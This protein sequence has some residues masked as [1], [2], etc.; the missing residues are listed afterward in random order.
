MPRKKVILPR[1]FPCSLLLASLLL[2]L[3]SCH[4]IQ[5]GEVTTDPATTEDSSEEETPTAENLSYYTNPILDDKG[6]PFV[7]RWN[8]KYYLYPSSGSSRIECW[9]SDNLVDW[10]YA[11]V[12]A[13]GSTIWGAYAPEVVY[14]N[15]YFYLYTSPAGNGH[16]V[17][18]SDSPTGPF[19]LISGNVGRGI[20]GDVFIDDDGQWY[21]FTSGGS[22]ITKYKMSS[23]T[24][25]DGGTALTEASMNGGWTEG[26]NVVKHDGLYYLT[27]TGNHVLHKGYRIGYAV[28]DS[29]ESLVKGS[30]TLLVSTTDEVF[31]TGHSST[32]KGPDLDSYWI[33]Y[34]TLIDV[35]NESPSRSMNIDR[36]IFNGS[37]LEVLG[38]TTTEQVAPSL[39]DF[40]SWFTEEDASAD[41]EGGLVKDGKL[42]L[43][44]GEIV[45]STSSYTGDF[46]AEF[47]FSDISDSGSGSLLFQ[48]SDSQN[49]LLATLDAPT[50][51]LTIQA[52]ESGV[53]RQLAA[54]SLPTSFGERVRLDC[55]QS[56]QI[57]RSDSEYTFFFNDHELGSLTLSADS[58]ASYRFGFTANQTQLSIS[59]VG[60]TGEVH[61]SSASSQYK[62]LP[63]T[64]Q[65][66]DCLNPQENSLSAQITDK[67]YAD[68]SALEVKA[69]QTYSYRV[70]I[71]QAQ[72][73]DLGLYYRSDQE[74]EVTI[75]V[76]G[77]AIY[78]G[79]FPASSEYATQ[80]LRNIPLPEGNHLLSFTYSTD[81]QAAELELIA[82]EEVEALTVTFDKEEDDP[83]SYTDGPWTI[84]DGKLVMPDGI[85][86]VGKRL[87]GSDG[88]GD[89]AVEID[90][91][92][93]G[94]MN[95]GLLVR[96]TNPDSGNYYGTDSSTPSVTGTD[97]VQ[98][99][100]IGFSSTSVYFSK[101]D[102]NWTAIL[103]SEQRF[104]TGKT[105]H[106]RVECVGANFKV[107]VNGELAIDYTDPDPFLNGRVGVRCHYSPVKFD[108]LTVSPIS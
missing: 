97:F 91:T 33:V 80:V 89:Y 57:E 2:S 94:S 62:P 93:T 66:K 22:C 108:N 54:F 99:Y 71:K 69:S 12:V 46:T 26:P 101:Q 104:R 16:Y 95:F 27:Y 32:V 8:G 68:F 65:A 75:S 15:G 39:P 28:G 42:T 45:L 31:G 55:V 47:C 78:T 36:L 61:G 9:T 106:I 86:N 88:W 85:V 29:I 19:E 77:S 52:I 56:L 79:S 96:A 21:F 74:I 67:K 37:V 35:K 43:S 102:Y 20:D 87:Y 72:D 105:Y 103:S 82:H 70:R 7:L 60:L 51:T 5:K 53:A 73:Y 48:Y 76:D 38:P 58:Q 18:R 25:F 34:H 10:E 24:D 64:I 40:V 13:E 81:F 1:S 49:Y 59:Y 92:P 4:S 41:W 23:P 100:Y 90:F 11:G 30:D 3:P 17:L 98:G 6:D 44:D 83:N 14:Y 84:Q 107:Y 50:Q 63:G